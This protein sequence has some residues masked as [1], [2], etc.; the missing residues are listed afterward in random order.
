MQDFAFSNGSSSSFW[1]RWATAVRFRMRDRRSDARETKEST[2]SSRRTSWVWTSSISR[3]R[4]GT[5]TIR[6]DVPN[7]KNSWVHSP[8]R[9]VRKGF[10]SPLPL[11]PKRRNLQTPGVK[12]VKIDGEKLTQLMI[13]YGLG[14][15]TAFSYEI[16]RIDRDYFND[17]DD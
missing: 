11:S 1:S 14:V 4:N 13:E 16:K 6:S 5:R 2:V 9:E 12:L 7:C 17:L 8:D 3:P 15:T 10:L